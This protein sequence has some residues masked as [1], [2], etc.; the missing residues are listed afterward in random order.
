VLEPAAEEFDLLPGEELAVPE[1][2]AQHWVKVYRELIEF[3]ELM[4]SRPEQSLE[5]AQLHRRLT[6]YGRRLR[7]WD[8]LSRRT[9]RE[10]RG[11]G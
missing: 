3:C 7:H 1:A 11:G 9:N 2:D 5:A 10:P 8:E 4:L 6:H